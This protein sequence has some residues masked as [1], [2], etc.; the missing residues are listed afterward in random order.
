MDYRKKSLFGLVALIVIIICLWS[1]NVRSDTEG[2]QHSFWVISKTEKTR[3]CYRVVSQIQILAT[4]QKAGEH[5]YIYVEDGQSVDPQDL[6]N[7]LKEFDSHIYPTVR[8]TFGTEWNPGRDNDSKITI[9]LQKNHDMNNNRWVGMFVS[10]D[11][12]TET[13]ATKMWGLHSNE[14]EMFYV[15]LDRV[16]DFNF[17]L[18]EWRLNLPLT[19]ATL[20]HEF[21]HMIHWYQDYGRHWI[22]D[23]SYHGEREE[24]WINEGCSM[25]AEIVCGYKEEAQK[26]IPYFNKNPDRAID[27]WSHDDP[28]PDYGRALAFIDYLAEKYRG[29]ATPLI[30][31]LVAE[32]SNG[33]EGINK[34]LQ[35]NGYDF[36]FEDVFKNWIIANYL[37]TKDNDPTKHPI[38]PMYEYKNLYV[39]VKE[40]WD[41]SGNPLKETVTIKDPSPVSKW[42]A[43]YIKVNLKDTGFLLTS[44]F[45]GKGDS[46]FV[47]FLTY[48]NTLKEFNLSD[49]PDSS[50]ELD[51][52]IKE[53]KKEVVYI[54]GRTD[55]GG[56]GEY[57]LELKGQRYVDV[58]L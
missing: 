34:V 44:T 9:L 51:T 41:K 33:I 46:K 43:D 26:Y 19:K 56:N 14:R 1:N 29:D 15:N 24:R 54:I 16:G 11:E 53:D 10:V 31:D 22:S 13:Q 32:E 2:D 21:Q 42:A 52:I 55:S 25:Y 37:D 48:N 30:R 8:N 20:A 45:K 47:D 18:K 57:E 38:N 7:L 27:N 36:K 5:A 49:P 50:G 28:L 12:Y 40:S 17:F 23:P 58:V 4:C 3:Q 39:H 6:E 35:D